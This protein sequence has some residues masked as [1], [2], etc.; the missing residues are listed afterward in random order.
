METYIIGDPHFGHVNII[1][2]E[3]RPFQSVE[4]MD[5]KLIS[6]WNKTVS[7]KDKIIVNGDVSFYEKVKTAEII[8][9]LNG[10]KILVMGNH[11]DGRTIKFWYDAGFSFVSKYPIVY[12]NFLFIS[13]EPPSYI[14]IGTP[15]FYF[16]A[17][18]HS[19]E[20]YQTITK[21]SACTSVERWNYTP[22]N[23]N[24]ALD[25]SRIK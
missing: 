11:D 2:Y 22:L 20:M 5:N 1:E 13:H 7:K 23:I 14:P 18:V 3:K 12:D 19:S 17:H 4:D 24:H 6:N 8:K 10:Y 21:T 15:Y 16:Y 25:L 9:S